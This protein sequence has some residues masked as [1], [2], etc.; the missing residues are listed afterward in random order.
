M[1]TLLQMAAILTPRDGNIPDSCFWNMTSFRCFSVSSV[2]ALLKN[3]HWHPEDRNLRD[4]W[5]WLGAQW[6]RMFLW[7]AI[8]G[9]LL[10]NWERYRHHMSFTANYNRCDDPIEDVD[11][12]LHNCSVA[13]LLWLKIIPAEAHS[14]FFYGTVDECF[15]LNLKNNWSWCKTFQ[16][17]RVTFGLTNW[18]L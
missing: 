7:L 2:Y 13:K 10:T 4:I 18:N 17:W 15:V 14:M 1:G 5:C 12:V 16:D 3:D 6:V 11:H 8:K 9:K